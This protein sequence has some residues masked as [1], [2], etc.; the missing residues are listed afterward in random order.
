MKNIR[1]LTQRSFHPDAQRNITSPSL[2][3]YFTFPRPFPGLC[4]IYLR[5]TSIVN[6]GEWMWN[7][8][9]GPNHDLGTRSDR[10]GSKR[11]LYI[12]HHLFQ[13]QLSQHDTTCTSKQSHSWGHSCHCLALHWFTWFVQ[14]WRPKWE[15]TRTISQ[16]RT[17]LVTTTSKKNLN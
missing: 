8:K 10:S 1:S 14:A 5:E 17:Q 7:A 3:N 15:E 6:A 9:D 11:H 13:P 12:H 2:Q 16:S 4:W